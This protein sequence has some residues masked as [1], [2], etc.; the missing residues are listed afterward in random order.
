MKIVGK[1]VH[2]ALIKAIYSKEHTREDGV[3]VYAP[4]WYVKLVNT[5]GFSWIDEAK[6][7]LEEWSYYKSKGE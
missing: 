3:V 1:V 4:K 7:S 5:K 2:G 6:V